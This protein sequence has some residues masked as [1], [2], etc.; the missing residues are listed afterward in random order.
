MSG[1]VTSND[2]AEASAKKIQGVRHVE[3]S[4]SLNAIVGSIPGYFVLELI[5]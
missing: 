4:V 2:L 3:L 5:I 1:K